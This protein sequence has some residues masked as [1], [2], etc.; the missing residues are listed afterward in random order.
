MNTT[1]LFF[2]GKCWY[3]T[4]LRWRHL[5]L[6]QSLAKSHTSHQ[7]LEYR[8]VASSNMSC[9]EPHPGSYRLLM[10][11]IFDALCTVPLWQKVFFEIINMC[12]YLPLY[13]N[14]TIVRFYN[15]KKT[16]VLSLSVGILELFFWGNDD[17]E[18]QKVWRT[19]KKLWTKKYYILTRKGVNRCGLDSI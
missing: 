5:F 4:P 2:S 1:V 3:G 18:G 10:K 11:G 16:D 7:S 19:R 8:R 13:G 17:G 9:L 14:C 6:V 12:Q 15:R